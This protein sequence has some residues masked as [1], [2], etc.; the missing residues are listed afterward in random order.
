MGYNNGS[1]L[2]R[3]HS[4]NE[5]EEVE[6]VEEVQEVQGVEVVEHSGGL[7]TSA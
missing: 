1:L 6:E 3:P 4:R 7:A 5:V 2:G